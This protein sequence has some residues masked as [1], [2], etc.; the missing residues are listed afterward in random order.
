MM[1]LSVHLDG[2]VAARAMR[3]GR[4]PDPVAL[5]LRAES[6]GADGISVS[7]ASRA[8]AVSTRDLRLLRS[9]LR[10]HFNIEASPFG[11]RLEDLLFLQP[12]QVTLV[13]EEALHAA[14]GPALDLLEDGEAIAPVAARL[15][16]VG[17]RI[18]AFVAPDPGQVLAA[19]DLGLDGVELDASAYARTVL[20]PGWTPPDD[21]E[22]L[23]EGRFLK[24]GGHPAHALGQLA[25][26]ATV[27][28]DRGL[29]VAAGRGLA[30]AALPDLA[31]V[32]GLEEVHVGHAVFSRALE[33]GLEP[34]VRETIALLRQA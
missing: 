15:R 25:S 29:G 18:V 11:G 20:R 22:A 6:G 33:V 19:S 9:V 10:G 31:T 2:F 23:Q 7:L 12:D 32:P 24:G 30:L 21:A 27:A 14:A 3:G 26:A 16:E 1:R 5:A 4:D 13:P 8:S 17:I 28:T 34:A